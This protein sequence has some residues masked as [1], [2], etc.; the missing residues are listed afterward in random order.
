MRYENMD[1]FS[2]QP[3]EILEI[4]LLELSYEELLRLS[5]TNSFFRQ[6]LL[7]NENFWRKKLEKDFDSE[8]RFFFSKFVSFR[9]R[10]LATL[11]VNR[12]AYLG[13][14]EDSNIILDLKKVF[15]RGYRNF[16]LEELEKL[17][18]KKTEKIASYYSQIGYLT[19]S[20]ASLREKSRQEAEIRKKIREI[21]EDEEL[22]KRISRLRI[23]A[24]KQRSLN[25][26]QK[27][28]LSVLSQMK[29]L[30]LFDDP[31]INLILG[32]PN[33]ISSIKT[34]CRV[35]ELYFGK[36]NPY[37][38]KGIS[39][40]ECEKL[41]ILSLDET[42]DSPNP[43][44]QISEIWNMTFLQNLHLENIEIRSIEGISRLLNLS[45]LSL[46]SLKYLER[47]PESLLSLPKLELVNLSQLSLLGDD[48]VIIELENRP[49]ILV[50]VENVE[51]SIGE[52]IEY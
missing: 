38:P 3:N 49:E 20:R 32:I 28:F 11:Y 33:Q 36:D 9:D 42:F 1:R 7:S 41:T 21:E 34:K 35:S 45:V 19:R 47:I 17:E 4:Q 52:Y 16:D 43:D 10:Y 12:Y 39:N 37:L 5:E 8:Q 26:L 6:F 14:T 51:T 15:L 13:K 31:R 2:N 40:V 27:K 44:A 29:Y 48:S 22:R 25:F 24:E 18:R 23:S 46:I 50:I 30:F